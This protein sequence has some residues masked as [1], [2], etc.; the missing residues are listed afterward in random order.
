MLLPLPHLLAQ[1]RAGGYAVGYFEAWDSYSLEAVIE[2]AEAEQAPVILGFGC[3]M[4][5]EPWLDAG[6]IEWLGSLGHTLARRT[7]VPAAFL[8]N[9]AQTY[10]ECLTAMRAGFN[11]VMLDTS[12]WPMWPA[13]EQ[14]RELVRVAHE[15]GVAV[16]AELGHLPDATEQGID[17]T[18]ASLTDP[19]EAALF[20]ER[21]GVDCLAVSIG[22]VHLLTHGFA[23]ID[24]ARLKTIYERAA[25]PLVIHGGTG[26]PPQAVPEAIRAGVAKFNVG[27]ILKKMFVAGVREA[28]L[29]LDAEVNVHDVIGSHRQQDYLLEGKRRMGAKVQEFMQLYG[30]S[31]HASEVVLAE[32]V[33]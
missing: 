1:A 3:M 32:S 8:L 21:T 10:E 11:T 19:E 6:G 13:M 31:G 30:S 4:V 33:E 20:V 25:V 28:A 2:A 12:T 14:T 27:T 5:S 16:E 9:E 22:N 24:L 17:D 7:R 18:L 29:A 26:F 15:Q 23:S